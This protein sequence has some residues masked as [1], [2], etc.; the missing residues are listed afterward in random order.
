VY[1][2]PIPHDCVDGFLGAYWRRPHAYLDAGVRSAISTFAKVPPREVESGLERLAATSKT[3]RG[4][5]A[6]A[7]SWTDR[8]ST[9]ATGS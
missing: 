1:P 5:A 6:T 3:A 2:L 8:R 4:R 7:T 9:S